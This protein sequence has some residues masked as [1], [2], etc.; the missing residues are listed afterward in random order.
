MAFVFSIF[1]FQ[2]S[3][4]VTFESLKF[5]KNLL[6]S[7]SENGFEEPNELQ[8]KTVSR[9]F[10]G[11]DMFVIS[12][13]GSGKTTT[14]VL[15]MLASLGY[16]KEEPPRAL[17]L[18]D[19]KEKVLE[20]V[21]KFEKIGRY[22]GLKIAGLISGASLENQKDMLSQGADIIV[23]TPDRIHTLYWKTGIN[24]NKLKYFI[25]DDLDLIIKLGLQSPVRLMSESV[26]K[27]QRLVFSEIKHEKIERIAELVLKNPL[28]IEIEAVIEPQMD[29]IDL[30]VYNVPNFKTKLNLLNRL[31]R[32]EV[33]YNQA[34]VFVNTAFSAENIQHNLEHIFPNQTYIV[35]SIQST[36]NCEN[37]FFADENIRFLIIANEFKQTVDLKEVEH[38]FHID[39]PSDNDVFIERIKPIADNK[40]VA[41]SKVFATDI[42]L[43]QVRSIEKTIGKFM[44]KLPL[45]FDLVI[46]ET[47]SKGIYKVENTEDGDGSSIHSKSKDPNVGAFHL[48]KEENSKDYNWGW[49]EKNKIF[50]KK[51]T[52]KKNRI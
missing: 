27:C 13:E 30:G 12:P 48:K 38:I 24:V 44:A 3:I 45:P 18:V 22:S 49:K 35:P 50:G 2:K 21:E 37:E 40:T 39:L 43:T 15:T 17:I 16:G 32:D 47:K 8:L 25:V 1:A 36:I 4:A 52:D 34:V 51:Y 6:K 23:G 26:P 41:L 10:S 46:D 42:E 28:L 20:L 33:I 29:T 14:I 11:Q 5:N 19:T 9:V 31:L 7:L